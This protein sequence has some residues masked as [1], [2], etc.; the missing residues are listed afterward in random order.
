MV[1]FYEQLKVVV[2]EQHV[3]KLSR[4]FP[5][6]IIACCPSALLTVTVSDLLRNI[7]Q[8]VQP[9]LSIESRFH[10]SPS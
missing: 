10:V 5:R 7:K 3:D 8:I 2:I 1:L 9:E 4:I 6:K